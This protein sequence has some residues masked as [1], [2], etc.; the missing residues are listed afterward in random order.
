MVRRWFPR[1]LLFAALVGFVAA[2]VPF[3][4]HCDDEAPHAGQVECIDCHCTCHTPVHVEPPHTVALS[5]LD[6][7]ARLE[8]KTFLIQTPTADIFQPPKIA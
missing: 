8:G 2:A 3:S 7:G 5:L 6:A 1:L 4:A